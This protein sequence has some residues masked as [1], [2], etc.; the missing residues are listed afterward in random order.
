VKERLLF[1]FSNPSLTAKLKVVLPK[2]EEASE[3][4]MNVLFNSKK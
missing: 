1:S 2:E 4:V 3:E